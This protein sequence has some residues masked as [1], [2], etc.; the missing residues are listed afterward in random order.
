MSAA[1]L[2][3]PPGWQPAALN[4]GWIYRD[5]VGRAAEGQHASGFYAARYPHSD[6]KTWQRRLE[7]GEIWRHDQPLLADA[8][9]ARGDRLAWHRPPWLEAAVPATWECL[10]DDGDLLALDKPSGLPVMPA[11]GFLEHTL[12]R[13][14]ERQH[15]TD[16]AG[17]PRPVHRLGRF[18]SGILLCARRPASRAWLSALLRESTAHAADTQGTPGPGAAPGAQKSVGRKI[19]RALLAPGVLGLPV[20]SEL[21]ITTPIA[22]QP[23]PRLGSI[24]A[25]GC[26]DDPAALAARSQ[27]TLLERRRD[28][29]LVEVAISSGRPHQIRIH[30]AAVGAPLLGDPLYLPGGDALPDALPGDGGYWLHARSVELPRP[31][32]P[33][34]VLTTAATTG[35]WWARAAE[36]WEP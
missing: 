36:G 20:G 8:V 25:A 18:T 24:W 29:D 13:L 6:R 19:Y 7:C 1:T 5:R 35:V 34:L 33:A 14:L 4:G 16:P 26:R 30:C 9:L 32:G 31:D 21:Q 2:P 17:V 3:T 11:G 22:R 12:L 23:H 28:A 10:C 15:A 27:L